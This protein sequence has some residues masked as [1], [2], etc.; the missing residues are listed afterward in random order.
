MTLPFVVVAVFI[1]SCCVFF[2]VGASELP[3]VQCDTTKG[4]IVIEVHQELA[5]LGA[6]HFLELVEDSFFTNIALYRC[7]SHF[8]TQFGISEDPLK[9]HW[10]R[11]QI[12]DDPNLHKGIRKYDVSFAGGGPNTRSS[13]IF[14]AFEDLGF[15]GK[16]PWETP[17]GKVVSGFEVLD[18]WYKGYGDISPF[19]KKGPDQQQ[20]FRQGNKYIHEHFPKI[21]FVNECR[22]LNKDSLKG[23]LYPDSHLESAQERAGAVVV[24]QK[25]PAQTQ[26]AEQTQAM[27]LVESGNLRARA[28]PVPA[29]EPQEHRASGWMEE[30]LSHLEA[31]LTEFLFTDVTGPRGANEKTFNYFRAVGLLV[32]VVGTGLAVV[33]LIVRGGFCRFGA[34]SKSK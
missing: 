33:M 7:V 18:K 1:F 31:S 21:D 26:A 4:T 29:A 27:E 16:E 28:A 15:L 19:N 24:A 22:V 6:K 34:H 25:E 3:L 11:T 32:V 17:F 9:K 13:Q 20:L 14:I 5:P 2:T 8:L 30:T 12:K 23:L 10:H